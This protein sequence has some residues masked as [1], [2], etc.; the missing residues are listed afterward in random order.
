LNEVISLRRR[1]NDVLFTFR[2]RKRQSC[3]F[4][5]C[6]FLQF[7]HTILGEIAELRGAL[8]GHGIA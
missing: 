5:Q 8:H 4:R 6:I 1:S 3:S 7:T 2:Q